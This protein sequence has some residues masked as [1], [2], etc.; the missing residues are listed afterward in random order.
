MA[1]DVKEKE[2][3][4][5]NLPQKKSGKK[6]RKKGFFYFLNP[7]HVKEEIVSYGF[8][9]SWKNI[10]L[11]Y[12]CYSVCMA[13]LSIAFSLKLPLIIINIIMGYFF[14][15]QWIVDYYHNKREKRRFEEINV[16][17]EQFL[18]SF[19]ETRKIVTSLQDIRVQFNDSPMGS[20]IDRAI[21]MILTKY[22]TKE[23]VELEAL[24][25]IENEYDNEKLRTIHRFCLKVEKNGGEFDKTTE[26]LLSDRSLWEQRNQEMQMDRKN[27]RNMVMYSVI[28]S[29]ILCLFFIRIMFLDALM[30]SGLMLAGNAIVQAATSIMFF[31]DFIVFTAADKR[32][33]IDWLNIK[34]KKE[35]D[36]EIKRRY[37]KVVNFDEK[38]EFRKSILY[39]AIIAV[40]SVIVF[41]VGYRWVGLFLGICAVLMLF[42]HR[43]DYYLAKKSTVKEIERRFPG[44]LIEMSLLMQTETVQVAL[45]KS[46]E[47][48]PTVLQPALEKMYAEL[49]DDPTSID[50]YLHFLSEFQLA[51]VKSAM[52]MFYSISQ[53]TGGNFDSQISEILRRNNVMLDKA[54]RLENDDAMAGMHILFM[55]PIFIGAMKLLVDLVAFFLLSLEALS[56]F[57]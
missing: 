50:P 53:G 30:D 37:Y 12:L 42:Q 10:L 41:I 23:D 57:V 34:S 29:V 22:D 44:W 35:S 31:L 49:N 21:D 26:I 1:D 33:A 25:L 40:I 36:E 9:F 32:V 6:V 47:N 2:K 52:K 7:K 4:P 16:Y 43:L 14:I 51:P 28:T 24:Q 38:R 39:A 55:L 19:H 18:Y 11:V 15:P 48:S 8:T 17:M 3:A 5:K 20:L 46:Y 56:Q 54:E 27:R 45:Y 13:I